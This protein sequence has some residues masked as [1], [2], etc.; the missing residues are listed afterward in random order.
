MSNSR[1]HL[2]FRRSTGAAILQEGAGIRHAVTDG[3]VHVDP[4]VL[5]EAPIMPGDGLDRLES[6]ILG[7]FSFTNW[8]A[9]HIAALKRSLL[10]SK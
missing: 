3:L 4:L 1:K 2:V 5:G 6:T 7:D 10:I 9:F 8:R